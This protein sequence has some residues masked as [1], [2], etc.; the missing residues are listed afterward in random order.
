MAA[1]SRTEP[2]IVCLVPSLTELLVDMGLG[3]YMV[4]RTGFCIHPRNAVASIPKVGG[5]KTIDIEKIK[6]LNPTHLVVN[7]EENPLAPVSELATFV[8]NVVKTH[9]ET[10]GDNRALYHQIGDEFGVSDQARRLTDDFDTAL[11]RNLSR[12]FSTIRVLYLIWRNPWMTVTSHTFI[13]QMLSTVGLH[14]VPAYTGPAPQAD[15]ARYPAVLPDE[16]VD[17]A[18]ELIL[19]SSEPYRFQAT[20]IEEIGGFDGLNATPCVLIDGEMT[21]WYGPRAI[22]GLDYLMNFRDEL[23]LANT[24]S[25]Q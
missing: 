16:M 18:P 9:V 13:S 1:D 2:R 5:T 8:P 14:S 7:R 11:Q 21:S 6:A 4:G 25:R 3:P 19:L 17:L 20:H 22:K 15:A 24:G 10:L 23:A 12:Q